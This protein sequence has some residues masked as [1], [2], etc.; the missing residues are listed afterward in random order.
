MI[1]R[2]RSRRVAIGLALV[3]ALVLVAA[4]APLLTPYNPT[5][6]LD[7]LHGRDLAPSFAHPLGTDFYSRDVWS[8]V[9]FGARISLAIAGWSVMIAITVGT[10]VGLTAGYVGGVVDAVLM[11][12]VDAGLAIPRFFV[13]LMV[14][15]LWN[16]VG[17]VALG[18]VIGLTGWFG[19]S[20]IV[21]QET[22][23]VRGRPYVA[24]ARAV[25]CGPL[26]TLARHVLP[27]VAGPIIVSAALG[28]GN[29]ILLE[30]GLSYLG[31]GV[32][33]PTPSWGNIIRDGYD[34]LRNAPW[35][36]AGAGLAVVLTVLAFSYLGES[37][38]R[39]LE[40]TAT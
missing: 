5:A 12:L 39:A 35:I 13:L 29:V 38:R 8:R 23:S 30:T 21:R 16:D 14:L 15:A 25:G 10:C 22:E 26:R 27:N 2:W 7:L 32:Q 18:A 37:L 24:A 34:V 9:L 20:R 28:V 33:Q 1:G 40:P 4:L 3:G 11:R 17:L 19:T 31:L 36:A 6:Q